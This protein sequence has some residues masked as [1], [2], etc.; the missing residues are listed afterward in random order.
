[1]YLSWF[2]AEFTGFHK[3]DSHCIRIYSYLRAFA[4]AITTEEWLPEDIHDVKDKRD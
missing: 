3:Y 1:M 4:E 2:I